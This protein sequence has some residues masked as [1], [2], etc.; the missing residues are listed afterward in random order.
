M[1]AHERAAL[2]IAFMR[3]VE[4]VFQNLTVNE[5]L[6]L[7]LGK[8]GYERFSQSFPNWT[9]ELPANKRAGQLSG[10]QKKKLSWAMSC[11]ADKKILLADEPDAGVDQKFELPDDRCTYIVISHMQS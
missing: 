6:V 3:Q 1:P 10:G 5:N 2:G 8:S 4:N 7:A 11:L 9:H